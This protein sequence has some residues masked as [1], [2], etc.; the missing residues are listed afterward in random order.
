MRRRIL[1]SVS[2]ILIFI[3]LIISYGLFERKKYNYYYKRIERLNIGMEASEVVEILGIP[4]NEGWVRTEGMRE[5]VKIRYKKLYKLQYSMR[6]LMNK[7]LG[8]GGVLIEI[9]LDKKDGKIVYF[10]HYNIN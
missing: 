5:E 1:I 4:E 6:L 10:I 8:I 7:L 3:I 9:Y 2:I